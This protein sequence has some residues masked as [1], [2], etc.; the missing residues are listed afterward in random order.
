MERV[1]SHTGQRRRQTALGLRSHE[2][3]CSTYEPWYRSTRLIVIYLILIAPVGAVM[4][5]VY[6]PRW[7]LAVKVLLTLWAVLVLVVAFYR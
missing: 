3:R 4:M 1:T 6:R 7:R 5:W 2:R